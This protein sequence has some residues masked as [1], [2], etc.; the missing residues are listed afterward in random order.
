MTDARAG[1]QAFLVFTWYEAVLLLEGQVDRLGA[2]ASHVQ[3]ELDEV[4]DAQPGYAWVVVA[5]LHHLPPAR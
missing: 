3:H 5:T 1:A 2:S 4:G